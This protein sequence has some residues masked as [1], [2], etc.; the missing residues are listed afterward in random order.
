[1]RVK[2]QS[3][4]G[5]R[6]K[7]KGPVLEQEKNENT[8]RELSAIFEKS[9][10]NLGGV[11]GGKGKREKKAGNSGKNGIRPGSGGGCPKP[12]RGGGPVYGTW[13]RPNTQK[14]RG[15]CKEKRVV[16]HKGNTNG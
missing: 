12:E 1:V 14:A 3:Q 10:V 11:M 5:K 8:W 7:N 6:E 2:G 4:W 9:S 15:P 16:Q 13:G